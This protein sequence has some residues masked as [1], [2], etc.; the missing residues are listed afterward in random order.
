MEVGAHA[1]AEPLLLDN[2]R[3][4]KRAADEAGVASQS[5]RVLLRD[6]VARLI[7]LYDAWGKPDE[8]AKWR[9]ELEARPAVVGPK[10]AEAP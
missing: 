4:L 3:G 6:A 2:Y 9:N 10:D 1:D 8:A 5:Q 7:D